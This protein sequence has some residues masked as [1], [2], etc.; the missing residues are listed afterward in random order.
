MVFKV[1]TVV[2]LKEI[3]VGIETEKTGCPGDNQEKEE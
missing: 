2:S 3:T 1:G